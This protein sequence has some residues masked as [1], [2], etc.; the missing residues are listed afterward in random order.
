MFGE[1]YG[2]SVRTL[3]VGDYSRELCGGTHVRSSGNI[4]SFRIL[5]DSAIAAGTRRIE[6]ITGFGSLESARR[7]RA[8]LA[9]IA[10]R[11]RVPTPEVAAKVEGLLDELKR[12][13]KDLEKARSADLGAVLGELERQAVEKDGVRTV[14]FEAPALEMKEL[15]ELLA[16]ARQKLEP[17]AGVVLS[18]VA[19]GVLV[20]AGVSQGLTARL[21]AGDVV[22]QLTGLLGGGGGGRADQAQGKGRD[23]SRLPEAAERARAMLRAAGL[24]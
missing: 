6:A 17:F 8:T 5:S 22:K 20:G 11:L 23:A 2:E 14:V 16:R 1:K 7:D 15:Q 18:R 19:D 21:A 13:R 9:E 4:G 10:G 3:S 24:S 12:V